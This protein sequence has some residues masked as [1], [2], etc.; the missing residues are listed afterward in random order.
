VKVSRVQSTTLDSWQPLQLKMM[1]L[2]GNWRFHEYLRAQGIPEDM[3][4]RLKYS[5]RAAKW[6]RE[7]LRAEAEGS[8]RPAP[9]PPGTGH[10]PV[11][12]SLQSDQILLDRIYAKTPSKGSSPRRRPSRKVAPK[13]VRLSVASHEG[14]KREKVYDGRQADY[15]KPSS[16]EF[17]SKSTG[18]LGTIARRHSVKRRRSVA[19]QRPNSFSLWLLSN[20][21]PLWLGTSK[22]ATAEKLQAMSSGKMEGFGSDNFP[23][24][25]P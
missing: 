13:G 21:L 10:L 6:Y 20:P 2:G 9:L 16:H 7:N 24:C 22:C 25:G 5:T 14:E 23:D 17:G 4:I 3:P 12:G 11:Q 8:A 19:I 15:Q 1:E 18:S